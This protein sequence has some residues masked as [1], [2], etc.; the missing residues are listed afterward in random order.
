MNPPSKSSTVP[1]GF[2]SPFADAVI[3]ISSSYHFSTAF[4][5]YHR[6]NTT[7]AGGYIFGALGSAFLAAFGLWCLL[8]GSGG[9]IS[10][11]TGADKRTSG[12]PFRNHEASK[13]KGRG[14]EL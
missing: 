3:F 9:H 10:K 11:R 5:S 1:A 6:Y 2:V 8:F 7:G 14:K 4:Y 12:F 13:R